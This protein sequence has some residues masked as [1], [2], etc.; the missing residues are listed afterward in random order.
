MK[1]LYLIKFFSSF[2]F[3]EKSSLDYIVNYNFDNFSYEKYTKLLYRSIAGAYVSF[4]QALDG[5]NECYFKNKTS[6]LII[7]YSLYEEDMWSLIMCN[8]GYIN[9]T[10]T[11]IWYFI[12][13]ESLG[14][15]KEVFKKET[16]IY[17]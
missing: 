3:S 7:E 10:P 17:A 8:G 6:S 11:N 4:E 9:I 15:M 13:N 14:T 5:N 16:R 1:K 12:K 2:G